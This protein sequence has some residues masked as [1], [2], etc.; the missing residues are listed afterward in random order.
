MEF[1]FSS[2]F[3]IFYV[4]TRLTAKVSVILSYYA[5]GY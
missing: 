2:E 4:V 5:I 3:Y 1:T